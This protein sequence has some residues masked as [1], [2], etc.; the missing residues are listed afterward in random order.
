MLCK[1]SSRQ[2][3]LRSLEALYSLEANYDF[4]IF[5]N[6]LVF[7][8]FC[9]FLIASSSGLRFGT[10][11]WIGRCCDLSELFVLLV[12]CGF[13]TASSSA[14][15]CETVAGVCIFLGN[16][17]FSSLRAIRLSPTFLFVEVTSVIIVV[18]KTLDTSSTV[19]TVVYSI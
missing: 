17:V 5:E 11:V 1:F 19:S 4:Y 2:I 12:F 8:A 7:L 10:E 16:A 9:R 15:C 3:H 13:L 14:L 18:L 6:F